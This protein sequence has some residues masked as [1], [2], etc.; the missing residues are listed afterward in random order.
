VQ[1]QRQR[2]RQRIAP[3]RP[4]AEEERGLDTA[5]QAT[6]GATTT[7]STGRD[8]ER[9]V[10][11]ML[12]P[13]GGSWGAVY[14]PVAKVLDEAGIDHVWVG[15]KSEVGGPFK[16]YIQERLLRADLVIAD[17]TE[18]SPTV[19]YELGFA[20]ALRKPVL[21][22]NRQ[23]NPFPFDIM[24]HLVVLYDPAHPDD[25]VRYVGMWARR[26]VA[27]APMSA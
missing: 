22:V 11:L 17:I 24:G 1:R 25:L 19:M 5:P 6:D 13:F 18:F 3:S 8:R 15:A 14:E 12:A 21:L 7:L 4:S 20:H 10:C 23:D 2:Q 27:P 16:E 9:P 26:Q